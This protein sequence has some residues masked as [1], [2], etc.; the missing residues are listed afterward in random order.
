MAGEAQ[1]TPVAGFHPV[2]Q[3]RWPDLVRLFEHHGNPGYCWCM[4]WRAPSNEFDNLK[5]GGRQEALQRRVCDG[6]PIGI[7]GY[8]NGEPVGWCS[9]APRETYTALE[10]SRVLKR[11][12]DQPVWSVVCFFLDRKVRGQGFT[13]RLLQAAVEF[14]RSQGATVVEGYPVEGSS[15]SYRWMGSPASFRRAGFHQVGQPGD[16]R[17]IMRRVLG[18]YP[19]GVSFTPGG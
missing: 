11:V 14:A 4:R 17:S 16:G 6:V 3:Q 18:Q 13:L 9:I 15:S 10:R 7:L 8:V 12:D 19:P 5:R 2:D 1:E